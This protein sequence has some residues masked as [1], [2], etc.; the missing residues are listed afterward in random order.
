MVEMREVKP[1]RPKKSRAGLWAAALAGLAA[2][3]LAGWYARDFL[4]V[5]A[6]LEAAGAWAAPGV[7]VGAP[8][9]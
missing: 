7:C 4:A 2:G 1:A 6:C 3:A 8:P 5:N 9:R